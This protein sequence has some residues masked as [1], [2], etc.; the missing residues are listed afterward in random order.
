MPRFAVNEGRLVS[1]FMRLAAIPSLSHQEGH[2]VAAVTQELSR[3]GLSVEVDD[4]G[5]KI[6]GDTGNVIARLP[7]RGRPIM[8]CCHLDT[9]GPADQVR[10]RLV[11]G[12]I[13]SDGGTILGADDKAGVAG[14]LEALRVVL[15]QSLPRPA[16][17]VV[18][19]VAE[20]VG[21]EGANTLDFRHLHSH[22]ALV[23]DSDGR[24]GTVV[25]QGPGQ[26]RFRAVVRG[27]A[28]HAGVEPE[29]GVNAIAI[30]ATAI[31]RMRLGRLDA[32]TTANIGL[33][34][35]GQASN[36]VPDRVLLEGEA[37]SHDDGKRVAQVEHM[38]SCLQ[39]AA[40]EG[41]GKVEI[42]VSPMYERYH[43]L[44][45]HPLVRLARMAM[46]AVG[47]RPH[48]QAS[49]GGSDANVFNAR[50]IPAV[51]L[52]VGYHGCHT[53]R[54]YI[55]VTQLRRFAELMVAVMVEAA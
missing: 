8:L 30:A 39:Q 46:R 37:R 43:V 21:L 13:T 9:V 40:A 45:D 36:I 16:L 41:G 1:D 44:P 3:L 28:A 54:E 6:G 11:G 32:E 24:V 7:G 23:A 51:L 33:I 17:E 42:E 48:L 38:T 10:P 31:S 29:K 12:R 22:M 15:E 52:G 35:G 49:G 20:E 53:T 47:I 14:I 27:K 19:T 25:N 5:R 2:V 55:P 50:G 34:S 18:F 4:A 26:D